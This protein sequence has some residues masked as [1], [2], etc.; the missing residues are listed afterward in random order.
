[1][2]REVM[3]QELDAEAR[4]R[5]DYDPL[6]G[7]LTWKNDT[8]IN[9]SKAGTRAGCIKADGYRY[10]RLN[11][12][13]YCE[14]RVCWAMAYPELPRQIDH[15]NMVRDDN[16]ICNLRPATNGENG[17][18]KPMQSNNTTGFKG[19]TFHKGTRKYHA[20]ICFNG[21]RRSLGYYRTPEEASM[22]YAK[23]AGEFHGQF[24]RI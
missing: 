11:N 4:R 2:S 22:A 5:F 18:N 14:H 9:N 6:T 7:I 23:A 13:L 19:V 1:M 3:R 12:K 10:V 16:R 21:T 8:K 17:M 20:K 15:I 24:A